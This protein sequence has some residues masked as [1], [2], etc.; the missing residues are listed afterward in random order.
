MIWFFLRH[1][2][3]YKVCSGT[4][5]KVLNH[6]WEVIISNFRRKD[7]INFVP[8]LPYQFRFLHIQYFFSSYNYVPSE[9]LV[10]IN[11]DYSLD[12][13]GINP[14]N[15][16]IFFSPSQCQARILSRPSSCAGYWEFFSLRLMRPW[17]E[18]YF[19]LPSSVKLRNDRAIPPLSHTSNCPNY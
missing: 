7:Y 19:P 11:I 13:Q 8:N 15:V 1:R 6:T 16:K 17:P 9:S 12:G 4:K 18:A 5:H 3:F 14:G 2:K 10:G